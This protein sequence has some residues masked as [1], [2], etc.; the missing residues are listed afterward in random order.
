MSLFNSLK[1]AMDDA[2]VK[3]KAA[4]GENAEKI[5]SVIDTVTTQADER[6]AGRYRDRIVKVADTA[7]QG[8]NTLAAD[9]ED[10]AA[11]SSLS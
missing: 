1:G 2:V 11:G 7:K 5:N 4:V 8:V 9:G 10:P 3:G 6:T